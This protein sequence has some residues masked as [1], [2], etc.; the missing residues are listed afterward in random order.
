LNAKIALLEIHLGPLR[1]RPGAACTGNIYIAIDGKAFPEAEWN[2]FPLVVGAWWLDAVT[3]ALLRPG[4]S[5]LCSFMDGSFI[6]E[7]GDT[8]TDSWQLTLKSNNRVTGISRIPQRNVVNAFQTFAHRLRQLGLEGPEA[9]YRTVA[10]PA[11]RRL[12]DVI[13]D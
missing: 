8:A 13:V 10:A 4:R 9:E 12:L 3:G 11:I 1:E 5:A 7:F 6:F 2:D